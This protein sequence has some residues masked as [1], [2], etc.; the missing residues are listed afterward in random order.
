MQTYVQTHKQTDKLMEFVNLNTYFNVY[1]Q[2]D[3]R[4]DIFS[5]KVKHV[6]VDFENLIFSPNPLIIVLKPALCK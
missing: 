4:N 3:V 2:T 6:N 5:G 1:E